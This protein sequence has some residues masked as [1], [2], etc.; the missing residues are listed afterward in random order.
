MA[1]SHL[2]HE[3]SFTHPWL[4]QHELGAGDCKQ[5]VLVDAEWWFLG[6]LEAEVARKVV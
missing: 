6:I 5:P 3:L 1:P 4:T 2:A